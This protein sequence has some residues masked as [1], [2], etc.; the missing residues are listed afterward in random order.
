MAI[1]NLEE[2][3]FAFKQKATTMIKSLAMDYSALLAIMGL[4]LA[5]NIETKTFK[6]F[7]DNLK[8]IK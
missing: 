4:G 5:R 7:V 1:L 2:P 3:L 6:N 8:L